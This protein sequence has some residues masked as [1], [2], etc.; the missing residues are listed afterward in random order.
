MPE[1]KKPTHDS[2][3][4]RLEKEMAKAGVPADLARA[5]IAAH[6]DSRRDEFEK[7]DS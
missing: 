4:K 2:E 1:P 6:L 5:K 7:G 3:R